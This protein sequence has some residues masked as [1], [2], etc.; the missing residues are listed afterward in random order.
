MRTRQDRIESY[1]AC[2]SGPVALLGNGPSLN[3]WD[4]GPLAK[5]MPLL[6]INASWRKVHTDWSC[7]ICPTHHWALLLG[8]VTNPP[9]VVFV[10]EATLAEHGAVDA[11]KWSGTAVVVPSLDRDRDGELDRFR[12]FELDRGSYGRLAGYFALELAAWFG[13]NPI[14][15]ISFDEGTGHFYDKRLRLTLNLHG[16]IW[17]RTALQTKAAGLRVINANPKSL[18]RCFEFGDPHQ[19]EQTT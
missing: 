16:D 6:G 1:R 13:Y 15:L 8:E 3:G 11:S 12:G 17:D 19:G 9:N 10:T 18:I 14:Y 5:R 7:Y 2:A 4:L